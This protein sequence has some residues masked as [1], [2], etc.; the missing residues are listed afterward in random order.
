MHGDRGPHDIPPLSDLDYGGGYLYTGHDNALWDYGQKVYDILLANLEQ[1]LQ[2]KPYLQKL[3]A[4]ASAD[5]SP[6]IR[7]MFYEFPN[8]EICWQVEDQYMFGDQYLVAPV[9]KA[10]AVS[11]R[12]YL[13][14]GLWREIHQGKEY[15]GGCWIE[16]DA[17]IQYIP[18][19]EKM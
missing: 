14:K 8:D 1:R 4:Q 16:A 5:G 18:V 10:G 19:F 9:L 13:P 7:A 6:L 2:M 17:P 15:E 11:R 3:F 12:V